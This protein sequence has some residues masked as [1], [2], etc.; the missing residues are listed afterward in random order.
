MNNKNNKQPAQ[1]SGKKASKAFW[2]TILFLAF[3]TLV[4]VIIGYVRNPIELSEDELNQSISSATEHAYGKTYPK[5]EDILETVYE[6]VYQK[7]PAYVEFHYSIIGGYTE[8]ALYTMGDIESHIKEKLFNDFGADLL[9]AHNTIGKN[10]VKAF[11]DKLD[12][13]AKNKLK[14]KSG[15]LGPNTKKTISAIK[16]TVKESTLNIVSLARDSKIIVASLTTKIVAKVSSKLIIK[17]ATKGA[18]AITGAGVGTLLC[19]WAGPAAA[20]CGVTGGIA[21]WFATD[22]LVVNVSEY[23]GRGGFEEDLRNIIDEHKKQTREKLETALKSIPK[24]N[25]T[26]QNLSIGE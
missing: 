14:D 8:L 22:G 11:S 26:F 15:R 10:Y 18:S 2:A 21:A 13:D 6:P 25:F 19:A 24:D 7:V 16:D 20:V 12:E 4:M 3:V 17:A 23:F 9:K 1:A 5:I